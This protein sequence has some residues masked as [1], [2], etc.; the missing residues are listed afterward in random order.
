VD[1]E[2]SSIGDAFA[3]KAV[4]SRKIWTVSGADGLARLPSRNRPGREAMLCWS[5]EEAAQRFALRAA[6]NPRV[7]PI[8]LSQVVG[9]VLPKQRAL[10]RLVLP[11][12]LGEPFHPE[13]EPGQIALRLKGEAV[14]QFCA[15][16]TDQRRVF[17]LEDDI[18]PAF[19]ASL[20]N[21]EKLTLPLWISAED[22]EFQVRGFWSEMA[23][24][25]IPVTQLIEK[26]LPF[27]AGIGRGVSLDHGLGG[28]PTEM[29]PLDLS[30]RLMRCLP[31]RRIA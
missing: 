29:S 31:Q 14:A 26:T 22:A 19:A 20:V 25:E 9:D 27:V 12:W 30:A 21:P 10:N 15:A 5:T 2:A 4:A 6:R 11:D 24:S 7:S 3:R 1:S 13:F 28:V 18:G 23:V 8:M 16:T 17:I